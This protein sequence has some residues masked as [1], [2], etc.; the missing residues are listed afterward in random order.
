MSRLQ[1]IAANLWNAIELAVLR[2]E[3]AAAD[4]ADGTYWEEERPHE[5]PEPDSPDLGFVGGE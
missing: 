5:F 3:E 2:A 1:W 4:K